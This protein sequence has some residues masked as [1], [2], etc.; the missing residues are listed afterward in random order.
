[1]RRREGVATGSGAFNARCRGRVDRQ[2]GRVWRRAGARGR[3]RMSRAGAITRRA[4]AGGGAATLSV[5]GPGRYGDGGEE[6]LSALASLASGGEATF[7]AAPALKQ[8]R[9]GAQRGRCRTPAE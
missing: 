4:R 9:H 2:R 7:L 6:R 5:A 1:V 3:G 8:I